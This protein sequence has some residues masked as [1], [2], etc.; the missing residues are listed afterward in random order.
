VRVQVQQQKLDKDGKVVDPVHFDED[1][2]TVLEQNA[3]SG[4]AP[5]SKETTGG[6]GNIETTR[7]RETSRW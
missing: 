7:P 1:Q 2:L 3:V 5:K 4:V 6:P